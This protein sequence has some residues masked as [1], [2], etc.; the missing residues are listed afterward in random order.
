M[1][2][3]IWLPRMRPAVPLAAVS[4]MAP[5][6]P[7]VVPIGLQTASQHQQDEAPLLQ[8]YVDLLV[9]Y[10]IICILKVDF[11][12]AISREKSVRPMTITKVE[13]FS[14]GYD[15]CKPSIRSVT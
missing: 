8:Y 1:E 9:M 2:G 12:S 13:Q 14:M 10:G 7:T 4:P 3:G 6:Q 11:L 15:L 5:A